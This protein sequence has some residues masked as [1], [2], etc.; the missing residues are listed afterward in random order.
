MLVYWVL[1]MDIDG[2]QII[3]VLSSHLTNFKNKII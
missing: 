1:L 2:Y 3:L